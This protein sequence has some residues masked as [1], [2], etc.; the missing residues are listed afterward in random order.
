[1]TSLL[2]KLI[3]LLTMT[4]DHVGYV[5]CDNNF[6][7][8]FIGRT[9]FPIYA[10]LLVQGFIHTK[11]EPERIKRY[12]IRTGLFALISEIPFDLCFHNKVLEFNG[13]NVFF[14]LFLGLLALYFADWLEKKGKDGFYA[15]FPSAVIA[16]LISSDYSYIGVIFIF[17]LYYIEKACK[18]K[19]ETIRAISLSALFVFICLFEIFKGNKFALDGLTSM[20]KRF[21]WIYIGMLLPIIP[22][23]LYNGKLGKQSK[24]LQIFFYIYY[25]LH[26]TIIY[27]IKTFAL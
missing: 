24:V 25:P 27:L 18:G 5:L 16:F 26:L 4:I 11:D 23:L 1:M 22:V 2:L 15:I 3:A 14:T 7:M 10:F 13:Q 17:A 9:A 8:R 12:L 20:M 19:S 6:T 21:G